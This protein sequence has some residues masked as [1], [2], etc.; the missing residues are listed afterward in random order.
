M[1]GLRSRIRSVMAWTR[2]SAQSGE[3]EGVVRIR[4]CRM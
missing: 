4:I 2:A 3:W 1:M